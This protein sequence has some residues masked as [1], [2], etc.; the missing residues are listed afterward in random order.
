MKFQRRSRTIV[1]IA[2]RDGGDD[3]T[4]CQR[5]ASSVDGV[6]ERLGLVD[7]ED[8]PGEPDR[9]AEREKACRQGRAEPQLDQPFPVGHEIE[10]VVLSKV[11][12]R[13]EPLV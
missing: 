1:T 13:S 9:P 8:D 6:E 4:R 11:E 5:L 2:R 12:A 7:G 10:R 3:G